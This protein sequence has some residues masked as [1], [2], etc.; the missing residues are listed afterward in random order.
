MSDR[1]GNG[2]GAALRN[3]KKSKTVNARR[4]NDGLEI[5]YKMI[6][7]DIGNVTIRKSVSSGVIAD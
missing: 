1:V 4:V 3:T 6:E 7:G 2:Y 5:V